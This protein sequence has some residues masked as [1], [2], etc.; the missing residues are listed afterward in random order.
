MTGSKAP[1]TARLRLVL[2]LFVT[3]RSANSLRALSNLRAIFES[4]A[5]DTYQLEVIDVLD[6]PL[7]ATADGVIVTPTLICEVG[8]ARQTLIG[9]LSDRAAA[10]AVFDLDNP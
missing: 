5:P 2:R 3:G 7:R 1:A 9:D 8:G 6:A 4:R 10:L